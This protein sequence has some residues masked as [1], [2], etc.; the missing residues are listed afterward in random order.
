[1]SAR[2]P[3]DKHSPAYTHHAVF[4][5]LYDWLARLGPARR[6][7]D[8]LRQETAGQADGVVLEVGVGTGLNFPFYQPSLVKHVDA[9][10]P[11]SAMLAYARRRL[12][13]ASV[14]ITLTQAPAEFLPFS[15]ELFDSVVATLVFCSVTD[16]LHS[17][18]EIQRVLKPEG[19]LFLF[20]HV[21]ATGRASARLQDLLVPVTTR[22]AGNCHWNRDT[23]HTLKMAGFQIVVQR[24]LG[25]GVH[26]ILVV[27]ARRS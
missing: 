3:P 23:L 20:E 26:P 14:P 24:H 8:P 27:Q 9:V 6:L 13:T 12:N 10:D 1:M 19:K 5:P 16:P 15:H 17:F 21:R 4:T 25:G 2:I 11:D 22:L 7:T 18:Q